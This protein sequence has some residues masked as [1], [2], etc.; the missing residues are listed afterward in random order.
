MLMYIILILLLFETIIG[1]ITGFTYIDE[2][3]VTALSIMAI[4][5]IIYNR[6]FY[7]TKKEKKI[8]LSVI[9]IYLL[10][11]IST[12]VYNIQGN[13]F[14]GVAS[15]FLS[16]KSFLGYL[17]FRI[18]FND[19]LTKRKNEHFFLLLIETIIICTAI[20]GFFDRFLLIF[21]RNDFRWFYNT[22]SLYFS[23]IT[24]LAFFASILMLILYYYRKCIFKSNTLLIIDMIC[25][26]FLILL[27][28]RMKAIGFLIFFVS[29]I[30]LSDIRTR[31][32]INI[33][34]LIIPSCLTLI[35]AYNSII[36]YFFDSNT[37]R[38]ILLTT[39][40]QIAKDYF[41]LGS[42]FGTFGTDFSRQYYSLLY[43]IYGIAQVYGIS[44]EYPAFICDSSL[45]SMIAETGF[46]GLLLFIY[47]FYNFFTNISAYNTKKIVFCYSILI[48]AVIEATGDT[49]FMSSRGVC[50]FVV[51]AYFINTFNFNKQ[52]LND[53]NEKLKVSL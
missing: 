39:S 17:S 11:I 37:A 43:N 8:A 50:L 45:P 1:N 2:I 13:I 22:T 19:S 6:K 40:W 30:F 32:K 48:Y 52:T 5:K 10:G 27:T 38:S 23:K 12:F 35:C 28:G 4:I 21:P 44:I 9:F 24:Y 49:I 53:Y 14:I 29:L 25:C 41:P 18:L 26:T 46:L 3:V 33:W 15:G 20:I 31:K 36:N 7:L 34:Y 51:Y 16:I 42:G 47:I